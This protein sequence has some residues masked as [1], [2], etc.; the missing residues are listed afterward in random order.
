MAT[1]KRK[2][3]AEETVICC[4]NCRFIK[5]DAGATVCVRNPPVPV[6]DMT[7]GGYMCVFPFVTE[8]EWC[9]CWAPKLN[10]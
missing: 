4:G 7:D 3:E 5:A 10:S 9:G 1:K 8:G 6:L 2:V